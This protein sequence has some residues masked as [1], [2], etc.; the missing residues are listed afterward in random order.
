MGRIAGARA[1]IEAS[2]QQDIALVKSSEEARRL[3]SKRSFPN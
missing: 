2:K 1:R 3:S